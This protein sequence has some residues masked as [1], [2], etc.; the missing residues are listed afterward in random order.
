[1][2]Q[3]VSNPTD[4]QLAEYVFSLPES[5]QNKYDLETKEG[6]A[7]AMQ[8]YHASMTGEEETASKARK[9]REAKEYTTLILVKVSD[10][11]ARM[12]H[13]GTGLGSVGREAA[14][15]A[16][17]STSRHLRSKAEIRAMKLRKF[18]DASLSIPAGAE[19]RVLTIPTE[20]TISGFFG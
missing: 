17:W 2:T 5:E 12:F 15:P 14:D 4:L 11:E 1:M 7:L 3:H 9:E 18:G 13:V 10:G 16:K 8:A 20:D 19:V 6:F